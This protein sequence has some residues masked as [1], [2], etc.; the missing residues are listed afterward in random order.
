MAS[1]LS[2]LSWTEQGVRNVKD[3]PQRLAA[4]KQAVQSAGGRLIFFYMLM[5]EY[6]LAALFEAP[7]DETMA[8][9]LLTVASQGNV[10]TKTL[11]AFTED[12]YLSIIGSLP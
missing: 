9:L 7:D 6:D 5:G 1:Y 8:R 4:V 3:S 11:K 2:L 10:R 12:E